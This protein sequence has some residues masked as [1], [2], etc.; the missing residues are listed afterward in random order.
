MKARFSGM[1]AKCRHDIEPNQEV[2][3][4]RGRWIHVTCANGA[5]DE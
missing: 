4:F 5:D 1:C 3:K 2:T